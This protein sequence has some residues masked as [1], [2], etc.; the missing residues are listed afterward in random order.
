MKLRLFLFLCLSFFLHF[1]ILNASDYNELDNRYIDT[2][3]D[4]LADIP[5]DSKNWIDPSYLVFS[6]AP[7]ESPNIYKNSWSDF[8]KYLSV[9]TGKKVV[10][11]PFS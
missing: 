3:G 6:Y 9:I 8:I 4:L 2:N 7:H 5:K 10:Y 1:N 11:F